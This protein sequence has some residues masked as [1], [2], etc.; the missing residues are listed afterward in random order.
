MA[1]CIF[2]RIAQIQSAFFIGFHCFS[3]PR[4]RFP[5]RG[6]TRFLVES[7]T[8]AVQVSRYV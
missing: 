1:L 6:D 5:L 7:V 4:F 2:L 3:P 8:A